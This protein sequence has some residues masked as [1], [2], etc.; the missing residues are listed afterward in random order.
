MIL[1]MALGGEASLLRHS[2]AR[3]T[4][5]LHGRWDAWRGCGDWRQAL[6]K[7]HGELFSGERA[8]A[9]KGLAPQVRRLPSV[10]VEQ[11]PLKNTSKS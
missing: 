3:A 5:M 2:A 4:G 9:L 1:G 7:D 8:E 6:R 11:W 10:G